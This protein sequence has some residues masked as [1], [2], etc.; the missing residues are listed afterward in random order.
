MSRLPHPPP[1]RGQVDLLGWTTPE[2]RRFADFDAA[3]P[4]IWERFVRMAEA[5]IRR[6]YKHYSAKT[7]FEA[8]RWHSDIHS[9]EPFRLNNYWPSFYVRKWNRLGLHPELPG[10]FETRRAPKA[11]KEMGD[12]A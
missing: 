9:D 3:N 6:D 1:E 8:M 4:Q 5:A 12:A 7:I 2:E 10:F 11:D